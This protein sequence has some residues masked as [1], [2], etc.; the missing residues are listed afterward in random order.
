MKFGVNISVCALPLNLTYTLIR[1]TAC[2]IS[3]NTL[4]LCVLPTQCVCVFYIVLTVNSVCL[5]KQH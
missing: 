4:K 1:C 2:A 3:F 5:P